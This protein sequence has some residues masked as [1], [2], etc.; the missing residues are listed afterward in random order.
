MRVLLINGS[1]HPHGCTYTALCEVAKALEEN[2][3]DAQIISIGTKPI[4]GCIDCKKCKET[5]WCVFDDDPVNTVIGELRQAD[6]VVIGSPVYYASANGSL[7]SLLDRVFY[8]AGRDF[9][10]KPGA[11]VISARRAGTTATF[12]EL[13][14]YFAISQM[15]IV[16]SQYWNMVHGNTPDEVR[17]DLEGM[18]IMRTLG[19]NMAWLLHSIEAGRQSGVTPPPP[20]G[21]IA[22]NFIR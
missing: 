20:E 4:R 21:K 3:V 17:Q 11:A 9:C 16:S 19:K 6:G 14:K 2:G 8:A 1:P 13:N 7:I 15:P 22:T 12:D 5:G 10:Y 18:Q